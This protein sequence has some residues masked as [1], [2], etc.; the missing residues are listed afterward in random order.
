[1][2]Q[3]DYRYIAVDLLTRSVIEELPLYGVSLSRKISGPGNMTGSLKL[4]TGE[5]D[6]LDLLSATEP[7]HRALF[8][9][10]NEQCVWA[11]PI[12][13]RTYNSEASVSEMT[14]QTYESVFDQIKMQKRFDMQNAD[15]T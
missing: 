4:G 9:L 7:G 8:A 10:R 3:P 11:G 5:Y 1:M 6:D 12:W 13:S 2:V 15:Q 14:G